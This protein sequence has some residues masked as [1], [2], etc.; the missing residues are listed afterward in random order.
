MSVVLLGAGNVGWHLGHRLVQ[1][2]LNVVQVFSRQQ[3]KAA[4]LADSLGCPGICRLDQLSTTADLYV[5]AVPDA[6]IAPLSEELSQRLPS[7]ARVLHCSGATPLEAIN[8]FFTLR[9]VL[10]PLQSFSRY[11]E[12]D[13]ASVPL[14]IWADT[15][16]FQSYLLSLARKLSHKYRLLEDEQ[17]L[18]LHLAAVWVNNF[19]NALYGIAEK[20]VAKNNIPFD[21][22][23]P[24]IAETAA[25]VQVL[26]PAQAQTG[27]AIR[28]DQQTIDR[29]LSLLLQH[30][31]W[32]ELYRL[33]TDEIAGNK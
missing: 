10:Y 14:C 30:P 31:Q 8:R 20:L 1:Q 11:R 5:L 18:Q 29:H 26:S 23:L 24:L 22:L 27:P 32:A 19:S 9:G 12:I 4:E 25:K 6:A 21:W 13:F 16:D 28:G 3:D 7:S 15:A 17:R 2:G 33:L